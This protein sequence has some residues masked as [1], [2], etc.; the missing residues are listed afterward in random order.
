MWLDVSKKE[1]LIHSAFVD[2]GID[3]EPYLRA[4]RKRFNLYKYSSSANMDFIKLVANQ[5]IRSLRF[6]SL[7]STEMAALYYCFKNL[8]ITKN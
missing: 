5:I 3:L 4:I 7:Y 8:F 6:A 1:H 2:C